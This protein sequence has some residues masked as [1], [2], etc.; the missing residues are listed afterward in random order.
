MHALYVLDIF[1]VQESCNHNQH[2]L[3]CS[4]VDV[5][6]NSSPTNE[7]S[8]DCSPVKVK[9]NKF[10]TLIWVPTL[11]FEN[12]IAESK[13]AFIWGD[14]YSVPVNLPLREDNHAI[15]GSTILSLRYQFCED[16]LYVDKEV[17]DDVTET[18]THAI[19]M[20]PN[21][22]DI[23]TL[24]LLELGKY[25]LCGVFESALAKSTEILTPCTSSTF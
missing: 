7:V 16:S 25:H 15:V 12:H 4:L 9:T 18:V 13:M 11:F 10:D 6:T 17:Y 14:L 20:L 2:Y 19:G 21:S 5:T 24:W 22:N 23:R 1:A 3:D 8:N